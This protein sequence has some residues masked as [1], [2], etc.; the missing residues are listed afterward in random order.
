[1]EIVAWFNR[2]SFSIFLQMKYSKFLNHF[3]N[4]VTDV[5]I[6]FKIMLKQDGF[7]FN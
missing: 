2:I 7:Q 3:F 5:I 4:Y 1:M 6:Q